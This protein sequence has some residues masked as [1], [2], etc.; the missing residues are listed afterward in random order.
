[1]KNF[2]LN[3][4]GEKRG[5]VKEIGRGEQ[6][7]KNAAKLRQRR[8]GVFE[9]EV[10]AAERKISQDC[11]RVEVAFEVR[12]SG[13]RTQEI[14]TERVNLAVMQTKSMGE[15]RD[16]GFCFSGFCLLDFS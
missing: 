4:V 14:T 9:A 16:I 3:D 6:N 10:R 11:D 15:V 12:I 5:G 8:L 1:M 13:E 2:F 7:A